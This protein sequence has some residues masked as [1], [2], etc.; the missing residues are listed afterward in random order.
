VWPVLFFQRLRHRRYVRQNLLR[1]SLSQLDVACHDPRFPS[2]AFV[3][4]IFSSPDSG[5]DAVTATPPSPMV[6][7]QAMVA[8]AAIAEDSHFWEQVE[9]RKVREG[10]RETFVYWRAQR[11]LNLLAVS[12]GDVCRRIEGRG[13]M[14]RRR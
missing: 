14:Q 12:W 5:S 3:E 1:F 7:A 8:D 10:V 6:A 4:L 2:D 11:S 9:K 13:E